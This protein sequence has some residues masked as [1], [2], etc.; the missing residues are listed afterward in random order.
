M[1]NKDDKSFFN[2]IMILISGSAIAQIVTLLVSPIMTRLFTT[3]ELGIYTL[4][5]SANTMF[6][7]SLSLRYDMTIVSEEDENSALELVKLS[8]ILCVFTS[9]LISVGYYVYFLHCHEVGIGRGRI[10][11][12]IFIQN[13]LTGFINILISYNNR[14]REYKLITSVYILRIVVQNV[15]IIISGCLK[16]GATGLI[17]SQIIGYFFGVGKQSEKIRSKKSNWLKIR[18]KEMLDLAKVHKKQALFSTPA[19][20]LNGCSYSIINFFINA[21]F[22]V[23]VLGL[24]SISFRVLGLPISVIGANVSKVY[25]ERACREKESVGNFSK[26][27]KQTLFLMIS[28]AVIMLF[29][30]RYI[31]PKLIGIIFG[32]QWQQ[33]GMYIKI[34]APMFTLRFIASS[35]NGSSIL[36]GK[37]K[38]DLYIQTG[39]LI[40]A[41]G[42]FII[43]NCM[44]GSVE[45]FFELINTGYSFIYI[46]YICVCGWFSKASGNGYIAKEI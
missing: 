6:G 19:A 17:L 45:S 28:V 35:I 10:A 1:L 32:E 40:V 13:I 29:L 7:A 24:Y 14:Y 38:M 31:V 3:G 33:A 5:L 26:C 36:V 21:L 2:S 18:S 23:E 37:Q 34:L 39:L 22:G 9:F 12:F 4:V 30:M 42:S 25:F 27:F 15:G 44:N 8:G 11:L 41:V 46:A 43:T 16:M 20:L